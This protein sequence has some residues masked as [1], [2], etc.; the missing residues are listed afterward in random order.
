MIALQ[1]LLRGVLRQKRG[2][3]SLSLLGI[4]Y[5]AA[6][7]APWITPYEVTDQ[8]LK[9]TYHPPT[10]IFWKEGTL[11]VQV[12]HLVD[13]SAAQYEP[14]AGTSIPI[15]WF[16]KVESGRTFLG[17]PVQRRLF[18]VASGQ[19]VYLMGSDSVGRD[20][21]SRLI[22]G[23]RISL[24]IGV[25]GV[26]LSIVPGYWIGSFSGYL[27]GK[28]DHA[29]MRIC[30]MLMVIP[31]LYL[32]LAL[33]SALG[34]RFPSDQMFLLIV[35]IM[36][37]IGWSAYARVFRGLALSIRERPFV[38]AARGLGQSTWKIV[39]IHFFPNMMSYAIVAATM[40]IPGFILG[41]AALSFLGVGIQE[42]QSSWG[43]MLSQAQDMKVFMLNLWWLLT[44]GLAIFVVVILFNILGDILRDLVDPKFRMTGG[45]IS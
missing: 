4:F 26:F 39:R 31:G 16:Q 7:L 2:V 25:V 34:G 17:I 6:F 14:L 18:T 27:G 15:Q 44:P 33:R 42:P 32:L 22:Y 37:L 8:D 9:R 40:G 36:S 30:E 11:Q 21:F 13:R 35:C 41:E 38:L 19:R 1:G 28:I 5:A 10:R 29:L 12:Y 45:D 24:C 43:L 20:V 23:A 3:I